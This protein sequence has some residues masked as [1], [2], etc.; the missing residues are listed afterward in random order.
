MQ[1]RLAKYSFDKLY[2]GKSMY[3]DDQWASDESSK[4]TKKRKRGAP[5]KSQHKDNES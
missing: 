5:K 2:T 3:I 4:E 1:E